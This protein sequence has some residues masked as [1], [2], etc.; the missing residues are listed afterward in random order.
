MNSARRRPLIGVMLTLPALVVLAGTMLYPIGWTLWLSLNSRVTALRG[1]PDFVG[2]DNYFRIAESTGFTNA[3]WQTIGLVVASFVLEAILGL[4]VALALFRALKGSRIFQAI[5]ALP[6]MV[7]PVVGALAWRFI[8]A[9]GYGMIDTIAQQFGGE[10]PLWFAN[11]WLARLTV[12]V[13]NLWLALPFDI[14]VM[15]AGLTSLPTEPLEAARVDGARPR[16]ILWHIILPL[17]KPVISIIFVIRMADAFRIFDV[18]YVLTA[19]GPANK[20]DVL[21]TYIYRQMFNAFDF[22][23]GAAASILLVIITSLAS[24]LVVLALRDR[25]REAR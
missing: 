3:L 16:Q 18:V 1:T 23:G 17:L 10:G 19:S 15:L 11:L 8:F 21:S 7:A 13:S 14:L 20:T 9:D 5:V 22:P 12:V 24:L 25:W 2:L 6:L 4:I